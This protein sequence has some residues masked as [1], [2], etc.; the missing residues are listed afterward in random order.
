MQN[1]HQMQSKL[2]HILHDHQRLEMEKD[3]HYQQI[4]RNK[5]ENRA[6]NKD[7]TFRKTGTNE[8]IQGVHKKTSSYFG[9]P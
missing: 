8:K 6:G 7:W 1:V 3:F 4:H 2:M 5:E 9:R